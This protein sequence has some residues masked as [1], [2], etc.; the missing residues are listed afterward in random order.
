MAKKLTEDQIAAAI[1]GS[2]EGPE[3]DEIRAAIERDPEARGYAEDLRRMNEVLR[4]AFDVP[5]DE[6]VPAPIQ[7][8]LFGDEAKV[9]LFRRA[10]QSPPVWIT[11]A[12]AALALFVAGALYTST[13]DKPQL[14]ALGEAPADGPL[15]AALERATSGEATGSGVRPMLTFLDRDGRP[16]REFELDKPAVAKLA[17]GVAC[18]TDAGRWHI[19]AVVAAP[20]PA[21]IDSGY[22]P[23]SGGEP[24][25]LTA[26]TDALGAGTP[27]APDQESALISGGWKPVKQ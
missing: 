8:A 15:H 4:E 17:L 21:A 9:S 13:D 16:C 10:T 11:A 25:A 20:D 2:L 1:D 18:R 22:A 27:L 6:P 5:G 24:D 12:A 14:I 19:E 23:A 3:A 26:A 7:A